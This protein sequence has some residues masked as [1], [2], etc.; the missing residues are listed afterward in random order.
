MSFEG[1]QVTSVC[2]SNSF[3]QCLYNC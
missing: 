2:F 3:T 1:L